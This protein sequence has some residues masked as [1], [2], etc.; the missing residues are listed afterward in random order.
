MPQTTK[1]Q[2]QRAVFID[3]DGV[4]NELLYVAEHGRID[5]PLTP[6]QFRLIPGVARRIKRL[7][8]RGFRVILISNQPG[9]AKGQLTVR[10]FDRIRQ[11]AHQL[12][13]REGVR[14]DGEYYCFHHPYAARRAYRKACDCRKPKPGLLLKA[15]REG[16]LCLASSFMVGDGFV[17]VEAGRKAGCRTVLISHL[18]S[19]LSQ[20]M[21]RKRLYPTYLAENFDE[22]VQ[23]ILEEGAHGMR[24]RHG[25]TNGHRARRRP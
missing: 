6:Q 15:A 24:A 21:T 7:Q 5:T 8:A 20:V 3:R 22:A 12:L 16:A 14:L 2:P 13:E 19:L 4:M 11:K 10:G 1:A 18:S 17:D 9:I 23:W 25:R